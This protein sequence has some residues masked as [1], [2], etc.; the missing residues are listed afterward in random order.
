MFDERFFCLDDQ[1]EKLIEQAR[2]T[3]LSGTCWTHPVL[4][5]GTLYCRNQEGTLIAL[6]MR[7]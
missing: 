1:L 7:A 4:A 6:N 2:A 3:V 5:N